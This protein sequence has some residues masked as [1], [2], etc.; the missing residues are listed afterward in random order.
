MKFLKSLLS[1]SVIILVCSIQFKEWKNIE[2]ITCG[3]LLVIKE[4]EEI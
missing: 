1:R 3:L 4:K 2:N